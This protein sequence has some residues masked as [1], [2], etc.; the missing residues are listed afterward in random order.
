MKKTL[1]I[2]SQISAVLASMGHTDSLAICDAGL[3]IPKSTRKID[4]AVQAGLPSF[5]D[6]LNNVLSEI[7][8]EEIILAEEITQNNPALEHQLTALFAG[9]K[10]T[11]VSHSEFKKLTADCMAVV[12]TG[13]YSP[14]A[15]I[16]LKSGV[17][18]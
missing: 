8:V 6:V 1:V 16:I 5:L 7:E 4:L 11:Y 17:V 2:N 3:P 12:R 9:K 14:Y 18:F 13:E 10:I 15:N